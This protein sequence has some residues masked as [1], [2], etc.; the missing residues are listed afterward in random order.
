MNMAEAA[1][2]AAAAAEGYEMAEM[3]AMAAPTPPAERYCVCRGTGEG[4]MI[5][6]EGSCGGWFHG[7]SVTVALIDCYGR[8]HCRPVARSS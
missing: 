8:Q 2:A 4:Y 7:A 3:A 6:C 1:A 5:G